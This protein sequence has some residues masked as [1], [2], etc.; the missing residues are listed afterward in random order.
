MSATASGSTPAVNSRRALA[1]RAAILLRLKD[2]EG[3]RRDAE[4]ALALDKENTDAYA[5]LATDR[6]ADR[7][8][9][10]GLLFVNRGLSAD[11][12]NLAL[13]LLKVRIYEQQKED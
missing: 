3:A 12:R 13:L 2:R 5:V 7:D 1:A 10:N 8:F 9:K 11:E 6:I 4:R